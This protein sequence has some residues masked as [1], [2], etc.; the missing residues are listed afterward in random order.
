MLDAGR[1]CWRLSERIRGLRGLRGRGGVAPGCRR[2]TLF[3][4]PGSGG[5][6]GARPRGVGTG[7][8][9]LPTI[10]DGRFGDSTEFVRGRTGTFKEAVE[11]GRSA[12]R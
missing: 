4:V 11:I 10:V 6:G 2:G 1:T 9:P 5:G 7:R 12:T 8:L 3:E